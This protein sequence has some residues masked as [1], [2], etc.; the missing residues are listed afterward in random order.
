MP[1][2]P[3]FF[4]RL[5][6][7]ATGA[8]SF[9]AADIP[10]PRPWEPDA[11]LPVTEARIAALPAT[12]QPAWRAYWQASA[13]HARPSTK[14]T[15]PVE[16]HDKPLV[17]TAPI[18]SVYST[19]LRLDAPAAWYASAEARAFADNIVAWQRPS[20]GWTKGGDYRR[21]PRPE[22]DHHDN[23]SAGTFDNDSTITEL[24][25]LALVFTAGE[26]EPA[27]AAWRASFLRGLDYVFASQYPNGGFPQIYPLAGGYHDAITFN[28]DAMVHILG[29]LEDVAGQKPGYALVPV[30][31]A[32][33]AGERLK[34][35]I[36]C[37]LATQLHGPDGRLIV[38]GQQHDALTLKP[39]AARNFEPASECSSESVGIVE[40]L[41]T[42]PHPSREIAAAIDGAMAWFPARA[43]HG[44]AWDRQAT[45]GSGL[46]ERPGAPDLWAR[47][48]EFGTGRP[49]FG[50]RD[51]TIHYA[52]IELS[53]ERRRGYGWYNSRAAA[54]PARYAAWKAQLAK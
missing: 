24:R 19:R 8:I 49:L 48:Y 51:R 40:F 3:R 15:D 14:P 11:F 9:A 23:W 20:G 39:C 4:P 6:L 50:D 16:N 5:V 52:V 30:D 45:T 34:R 54:L 44:V 13:S 35:G 37:V 28:D 42:I 53:S 10:P 43:L 38:W 22:D 32:A 21:T 33:I 1:Q 26:T 7:L 2:L 36:A 27:A 12:E 18:P 46:V 47:F 41:M 29:L 17:N 31:R 25:F